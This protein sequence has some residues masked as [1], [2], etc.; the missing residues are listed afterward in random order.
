MVQPP[1]P[2]WGRPARGSACRTDSGGRLLASGPVATRSREEGGDNLGHAGR[3]S[4]DGS[5]SAGDLGWRW[6]RTLYAGSAGYY[7]VG[8]AAYPAQLTD[9]L[10]AALRL[11]GT[12]RLVD[13][14]YGPGSLTLLLAPHF[15]E[16]IGVDADADMLAEAARLADERDVRN[17]SWRHLRGEDLPADVPVARVMTFAQSFHWMDRP[18]RRLRCP[19]DGRSG[20]CPGARPRHHASR[21]R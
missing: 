6:D 7:P 21:R 18:Q 11:D 17:V 5:A 3:M 19:R 13:V 4:S 8:R 1:G 10:V 2:S 16:V 9:M 15:A 14:G 12:G 20:R